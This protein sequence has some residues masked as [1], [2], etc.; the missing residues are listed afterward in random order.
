MTPDA[1]SNERAGAAPRPRRVMPAATLL[2]AGALLAGISVSGP[3]SGE[4]G[5]GAQNLL[6][7][8]AVGMRFEGPHEVP[9]GWVT[10]RFENLSGMV[11]FAL[12]D[13]L[14]PGVDAQKMASAVALPFQQGMDFINAGDAEAAGEAFGRLPDWMSDVVYLGGP[15]LLSGGQRA[16]ATMFLEPGNYMLEC[17]IKTNGI[18]HSYNPEPGQ[19]GMVHELR[20]TDEAG[21]AAEPDANVTLAVSSEGFEVTAGAFHAGRNTIRAEFRDQKVYPHFL[22]HDVHVIRVGEDTDLDAVAAWMD[23]SHPDGF[24]SPAPAVFLGGVNDMPAGT[25]AYFSVDLEPG[26]YALVAEVPAPQA[27]G[28]LLPFTVKE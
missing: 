19:L 16:E 28:L 6:E 25:T 13:R 7:L 26:E 2:L 17:Y 18:F 24:E 21:G 1:M 5:A 8:R 15:G 20:V 9:S 3:A 4:A 23:W 22:G 12:V 10:I 14:P 11:H 27:H